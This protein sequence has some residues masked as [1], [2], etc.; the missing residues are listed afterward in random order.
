MK[1]KILLF[2]FFVIYFSS[3]AQEKEVIKFIWSPYFDDI[4]LTA[5][6]DKEFTVDWGDGCNIETYSGTG[7]IQFI[8]HSYINP[9]WDDYQ[10]I[11][12]GVTTE[13]KFTLFACYMSNVND[14]D[15]NSCI[16][17]E[18]LFCGRNPLTSLDLT[19]N[20]N[21]KVLSCHTNSL[22]NLNL[23]ENKNLETL[24]CGGISLSSLN[25]TE[26]KNLKILTI[27][28]AYG[29]GNYTSINNLDLSE[30]TELIE[31]SIF[32]YNQLTSLDLSANTKLEIL[33]I[34]NSELTE[35]NLSSNVNLRKIILRNNP[36]I[37]LDL[38]KNLKLEDLSLHESL[39]TE[40]NLNYNIELK[41][42][43]CFNNRLLSLDLKNN[44]KL[45]QINC[46]NNKLIN[47]FVGESNKIEELDCSN[48]QLEII[49][50]SALAE[51][52]IFECTRNNLV[53]LDLS[54][55]TKLR[56]LS[57]RLNN[58]KSINL[59]TNSIYTTFRCFENQLTLTDLFNV[60][61]QTPNMYSK[62]LGTQRLES[63]NVPVG[64]TVDFSSQSEFKDIT[65]VFVINKDGLPSEINNDYTITNGI[66]TFLQDGIFTVTMT[67]AAIVSNYLYPA[68]VIAEFKVG[69]ANIDDVSYL[70]DIVFYPNPVN[71]ILYIKTEKETIPE[72]KLYSLEGQLLL[73][74]KGNEIDVSGFAAGIYMLEV[75]GKKGKVVKN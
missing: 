18:F 19:N 45:T 37:S 30:N 35:M 54:A 68:K 23:Y 48:N 27:G 73:N 49:D 21:L 3:K 7:D 67:N 20:I 38:S 11:I 13:C 71:D 69:Y 61:E 72:V 65:T 55:N 31:L 17:L 34:R 32:D 63:Q 36:L 57:C 58:L 22:T 74:I 75:D 70:S 4:Y 25:L 50:L 59:C 51:L 6:E 66:I 5:T 14:L 64:F 1:T 42:L 53:S 41:K 26:N 29:P 16:S 10:V 2:L 9:D 8:S 12:T 28:G 40:I 60:S 33:D 56:N 62:H 44:S 52:E 39:L 46:S 43:T 15:F 24:T 47:L